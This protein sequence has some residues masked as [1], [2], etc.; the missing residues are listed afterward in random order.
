MEAGVLQ[1]FLDLPAQLGSAQTEAGV[2]QWFPGLL[3][4][5]GVH[6]PARPTGTCTPIPQPV[7]YLVCKILLSW[8]IRSG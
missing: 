6:G 7:V 2:L 5:L 1:W 3:A 4:Q 8:S